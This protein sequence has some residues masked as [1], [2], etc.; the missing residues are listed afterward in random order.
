MATQTKSTKS[1]TEAAAPKAAAP[2]A[3]APKAAAPK[4]KSVLVQV[5]DSWEWNEYQYAGRIFT[6][7]GTRVSASDPLLNE[8]TDHPYLKIVA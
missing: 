2:K 8:L 7:A 3:A 6:K 4:A 5:D 1:D